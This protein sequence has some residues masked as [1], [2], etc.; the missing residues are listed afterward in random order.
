[1]VRALAFCVV[2]LA[3]C[4]AAAQTVRPRIVSQPETEKKL[5]IEA[6]APTPVVACEEDEC[7]NATAVASADKA[8]DKHA[9]L[10][11]K[12]AEL[13]CLQSEIDALRAETGTPQLILVKVKAIEISRTK[14][15][16][17]GIDFSLLQNDDGGNPIA[18]AP[19]ESTSFVRFT[20]VNDTA[21][22][23]GM[24]ELLQRENKVVDLVDEIELVFLVA[25]ELVA[26]LEALQHSASRDAA[27]YRT[28]TSESK[29]RLGERSLRVTKPRTSRQK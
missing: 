11:Q 16:Q 5:G 4:T 3:A 13:N 23:A 9:L 1:M 15:R 8:V 28:A 6:Q 24:I 20:T 7:P 21:A 22:V 18:Q 2:V 29:E 19:P 14:L 17:A 12:L 25:P 10:K 27:E 26:P